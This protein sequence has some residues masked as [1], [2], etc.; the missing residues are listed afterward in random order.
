MTFKLLGSTWVNLDH[1]ITVREEGVKTD[2]TI[3]Q[4]KSGKRKWKRPDYYLITMQFSDGEVRQF[5]DI[6]SIDTTMMETRG[7]MV[8]ALPGYFLVSYWS[9]FNDIEKVPVVAWRDDGSS[10]ARPVAIDMTGDDPVL[11]CPDG[12]VVAPY[13]RSWP[14]LD[15]YISSMRE[16]AAEE[17]EIEAKAKEENPA[18]QT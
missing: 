15:R 4:E 12:S 3:A 6:S 16:E 14:N 8:P 7:S 9:E 13:D 1:V 17:R 5:K 11:L 2:E 10:L 18:E